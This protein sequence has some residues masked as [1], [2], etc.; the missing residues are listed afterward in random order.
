M[1]H[2]I[3]TVLELLPGGNKYRVIKLSPTPGSEYKGCYLL[4][5]I[6]FWCDEDLGDQIYCNRLGQRIWVAS[7]HAD[8]MPINTS[9]IYNLASDG[10]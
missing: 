2:P 4:E 7:F 5:C 8:F 1:K 6:D 3:N 10:Q 9:D